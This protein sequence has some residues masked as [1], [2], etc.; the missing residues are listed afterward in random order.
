V[1]DTLGAA[2]LGTIVVTGAGSTLLTGALT[3]G[4]GTAT[5]SI[6]VGSGGD[7]NCTGAAALHGAV[8]LSGGTLS[9]TALTIEAGASVSGNGTVIGGSFIDLGT[10]AVTSGKLTCIGPVTGTGSLSIGGAGDLALGSTEAAGVGVDFTTGGGTLSAVTS[11]DI[12]GTI[13]GWSSGDFIALQSQT[14]VSDSYT[15]GTLT[16]LGSNNTTLGVLHFA[17]ALATGDFA[18]SHPAG[19]DT[20]IAFHS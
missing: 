17:G 6:A 8:T 15:N 14:V 1:L 16:L 2:T 13:T 9:A 12:A 7:V 11:A 10:V 18:I 20:L 3:V 5:G 4:N 19:I